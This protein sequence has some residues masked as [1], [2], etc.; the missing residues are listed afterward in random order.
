VCDGEV[1]GGCTLLASC[2]LPQSIADRWDAGTAK[3]CLLERAS[4]VLGELDDRELAILEDSLQ[5][6]RSLSG[7]EDGSV[8][9]EQ[10]IESCVQ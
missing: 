3:D 1:R 7:S 10:A 4:A 2:F 6:L 5:R 9:D 8:D